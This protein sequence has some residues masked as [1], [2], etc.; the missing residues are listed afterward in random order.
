VRQTTGKKSNPAKAL[1]E[2]ELKKLLT[3]KMGL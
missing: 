1:R 3:P 2:F